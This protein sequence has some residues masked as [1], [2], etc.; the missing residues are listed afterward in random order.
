MQMLRYEPA[1]CIGS[2]LNDVY[3]AVHALHGLVENGCGTSLSLVAYNV[4]RLGEEQA[5]GKDENGTKKSLPSNSP[6]NCL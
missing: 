2:V 5:Y 1:I 4:A 3:E 6:N